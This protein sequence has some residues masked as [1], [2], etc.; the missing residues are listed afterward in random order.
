M[1]ALSYALH[2]LTGR[3]DAAAGAILERDCQITYASFL[4]LFATDL[5]KNPTQRDL[6]LWLGSSDASLSRQLPQL[7]ADGWIEVRTTRGQGHRRQVV[8]TPVGKALV[9]RAAAL[10]ERRFAAVVRQA[11]VDVQTY[12]AHTTAIL[13]LLEKP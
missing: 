9:R 7:A 1:A 8:L 12:S 3:M 11:G 13:N 2:V 4:T 10:L 5:L 6:A